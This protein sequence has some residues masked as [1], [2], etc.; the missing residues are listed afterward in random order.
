MRKVLIIVFFAAVIGL[1]AFLLIS[2]PGVFQ[3][4]Y[5]WLIGLFGIVTWPFRKL[6]DWLNANDE[7][8]EIGQSNENLKIELAQIK[9]ELA[10][11]QSRLEEERRKNKRRIAAL[12][13][14]ISQEDQ[15][16]KA[17]KSELEVLKAQ[18][19]AEFKATLAPE[20]KQKIE[21]DIW[22]GVDFGL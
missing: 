16:G 22:K 19:T 5:L 6:W 21:E 15:T 2:N 10:L 13:K 4:I 12:Q 1:I 14:A 18:T 7:L 9:K 20:E 11:A 17:I 8:K 3:K